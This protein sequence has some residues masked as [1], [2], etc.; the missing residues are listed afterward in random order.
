MYIYL[1]IDMLL[2]LEDLQ[3]EIRCNIYWLEC[4][5]SYDQA[6]DIPQCTPPMGQ[7]SFS[8]GHLYQL[9]NKV[10]NELMEGHQ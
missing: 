10:V 3:F 6:N 1:H 7:V 9:S 8:L 5:L 4:L 2:K